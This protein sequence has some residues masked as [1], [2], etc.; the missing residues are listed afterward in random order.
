MANKT[1][2][3]LKSL[4]EDDDYLSE[5]N[6][7]HMIDSQYNSLDDD[8]ETEIILKQNADNA[9]GLYSNA[10]INGNLLVDQYGTADATDIASNDYVIDMHLV[11]HSLATAP[12]QYKLT[13]AQPATLAES[14]S[15]KLIVQATE[16][17]KLMYYLT[18]IEDYKQFAGKE[19]T[20]SVWVKTNNTDCRLRIF[21]GISNQIPTVAH[22]GGGAWELLTCTTT[23]NSA[24]TILQVYVGLADVALSG[25]N[26][27]VNDYV[28]ITGM[29]LTLGTERLPEN[30]LSYADELMKCQ[31]YYQLLLKGIS[32]GMIVGTT[33]ST[34]DFY[35]VFTA[36]V[37]MRQTPA[38]AVSNVTDF[39]ILSGTSFSVTN[40][41]LNIAQSSASLF[42]LVWASSGMTI[43]NAGWIRSIGS[44]TPVI[45]FDANL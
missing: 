11:Q 31:R 35:S 45:A 13:A 40:I 39:S 10:I 21:D 1:R 36:I 32:K 29:Q 38:L 23:V 43:G 30:P 24:N 33:Q 4:F 12:K 26:V 18:K 9:R 6:F 16:T 3:E 27:A 19:V 20:L 44:G 7:G 14:N 25:V 5:E 17:A 15:I 42:E 28:E 41:T 2:V 8:L 37:P 22:T 34:T